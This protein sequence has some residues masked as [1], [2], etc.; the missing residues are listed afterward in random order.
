[1]FNLG[2]TAGIIYNGK[3]Y[4]SASMSNGLYEMDM[5]TGEASLKCIFGREKMQSFLHRNAFIFE[6]HAWFIP[7]RGNYIT[8][9]NLDTFNMEYFDYPHNDC[10]GKDYFAF[11]ISKR[12]G[13]KIYLLPRSINEFTVIDMSTD[14]VVH[15]PN[16]VHPQDEM[17]IDFVVKKEN[18]FV[19]FYDQ[20]YIRKI[21][22]D[23]W[24]YEDIE[25]GFKTVSICDDGA[26]IWILNSDSSEVYRYDILDN[27]IKSSVLIEGSDRFNGS[28]CLNDEIIF[29]PL[30]S[31]GFLHITKNSM[32]IHIDSLFSTVIKYPSKMMQLDTN[33]EDI[34]LGTEG[35]YVICNNDDTIIKP[36]NITVEGYLLQLSNYI[37]SKG[38]WMEFFNS[39]RDWGPENGIGFEGYIFMLNNYW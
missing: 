26:D 15:I 28:L 13:N 3:I 25:C 6:N 24:T 8:K 12:K 30:D 22:M 33:K 16:I 11:I 39:L 36:I 37:K 31:M 14:E 18:V 17:A 32:N 10:S 7:Q 23:C 34:L 2:F 38:E 20:T 1:M 9:V 21:N 29:F 19:F 35:Y 27:R 4:F 5:A